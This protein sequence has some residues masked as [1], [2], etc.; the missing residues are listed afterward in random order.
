MAPLSYA[1]KAPRMHELVAWL[2]CNDVEPR[3]VPYPTSVFVESVDGVEWFIRFDAYARSEAGVIM[4]DPAADQFAYVEQLVVMV[5]DPPMWWLEEAAPTGDGAAPAGP[6]GA[7]VSA[8]DH[9]VADG[10]CKGA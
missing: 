3:D 1:V 10:V 4:Y 9:T 7:E 6:A 2:R 5:N 8:S